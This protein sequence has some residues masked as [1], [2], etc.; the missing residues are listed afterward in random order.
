MR[1]QRKA[2]RSSFYA[3]LLAAGGQQDSQ[4]E[5]ARIAARHGKADRDIRP[6]LYDLWLGCLLQTVW[7]HDPRC[8]PRVEL[9]WR[10][11]MDAG[12]AFMKSRYDLPQPA[13]PAA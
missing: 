4:A 5:L 11:V 3:L 8:T 12:I 9:A 6:H 1:R 10:H 7:Q 2:L 13:P